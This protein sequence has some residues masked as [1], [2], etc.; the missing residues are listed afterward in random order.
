MS[1]YGPNDEALNGKNNRLH[2]N[3]HHKLVT[4]VS[5]LY[6]DKALVKCTSRNCN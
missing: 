5:A 6:M 1:Y 3:N 4:R 2:H